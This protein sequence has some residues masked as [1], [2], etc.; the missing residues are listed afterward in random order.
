M[1][2]EMAE[3]YARWRAINAAT[4]GQHTG[5]LADYPDLLAVARPALAAELRV[6]PVAPTVSNIETS[7][8]V[9][10]KKPLTATAGNLIALTEQ[11]QQR[12]AQQ[13][14]AA[15]ARQII[16]EEAF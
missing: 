12:A 1:S 2:A 10:L 3:M 6:Q 11:E 5:S 16:N 8:S 13:E 7:V 9:P 15:T 4:E 14:Q